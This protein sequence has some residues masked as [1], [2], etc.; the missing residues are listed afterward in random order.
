MNDSMK[1]N[2]QYPACI[3]TF[4]NPSTIIIEG[5][6]E[7]NEQVLV[8]KKNLPPSS[9]IRQSEHCIVRRF[10]DVV[11]SHRKA[12]KILVRLHRVSDI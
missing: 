1:L 3:D 2:A 9:V 10:S 5:N 11:R 12:Y 8:M 7:A 6:L 4:I